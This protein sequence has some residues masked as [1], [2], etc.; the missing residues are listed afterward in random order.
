MTAVTA[1]EDAKDKVDGFIIIIIVE[2]TIT[3]EEA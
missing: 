2:E 1:I 3:V